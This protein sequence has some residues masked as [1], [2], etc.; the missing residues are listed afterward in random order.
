MNESQLPLL[1][2]MMLAVVGV[3]V[4]LSYICG[5]Y[6]KARDDMENK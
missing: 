5:I 4:G 2:G 3:I 1:I 6:V